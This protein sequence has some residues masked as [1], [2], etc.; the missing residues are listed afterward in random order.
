MG[1]WTMTVSSSKSMHRG[2]HVQSSCDDSV[3]NHSVLASSGTDVCRLNLKTE[4]IVMEIIYFYQISRNP[5][6]ESSFDGINV[7]ESHS[8]SKSCDIS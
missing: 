1:L 2:I 5:Q 7:A 8:S 3:S 6:M 4:V